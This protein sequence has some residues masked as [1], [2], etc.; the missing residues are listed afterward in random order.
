MAKKVKRLYAF[1]NVIVQAEGEEILKTFNLSQETLLNEISKI[2]DEKI[3]RPNEMFKIAVENLTGEYFG[4]VSKKFVKDQKEYILYDQKIYKVCE[5][6]IL[7]DER[8]IKKMEFNKKRN[9][10]RKKFREEENVILGYLISNKTK[11]IKHIRNHC[12]D[13]M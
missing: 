9:E 11:T 7:N 1:K 6:F 8:F 10:E 12:P 2:M 4:N 5:E 13:K 3:L